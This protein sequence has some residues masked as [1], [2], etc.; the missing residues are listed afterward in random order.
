MEFVNS[1]SRA[2]RPG[3]PAFCIQSLFLPVLV[4]GDSHGWPVKAVSTTE[5]MVSAIRNQMA[6]TKNPGSVHSRIF[7]QIGSSIESSPGARIKKEGD[8]AVSPSFLCDLNVWNIGGLIRDR[9][10]QNDLLCVPCWRHLKEL[11]DWILFAVCRS[12]SIP[13]ANRSSFRIPANRERTRPADI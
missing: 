8:T 1:N 7:S 12:A 2:V 6:G 13:A 9:L 5:A 4:L 11:E 10:D 3:T